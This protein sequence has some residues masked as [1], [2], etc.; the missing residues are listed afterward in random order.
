MF[1]VISFKDFDK[2]HINNDNVLTSETMRIIV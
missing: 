1:L 2:F